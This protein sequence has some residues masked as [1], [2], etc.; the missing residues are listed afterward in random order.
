[1][2]FK[3]IRLDKSTFHSIFL[4]HFS[5]QPTDDQEILVKSLIDFIFTKES[6][7]LFLLKGYAGTGKTTILGAF[8]KSLLEAKA[9][10]KLLAPTGRAAKVLAGKSN[11]MANTIHKFIYRRA[12]SSDGAFR[13]SLMPN[14]HKH[15]LFIVDEASMIGDYTLQNDGQVSS[16]NLLEDLME[17]VYSGEGCKLILLGD[18]GQLPPVGADFS[19]ALNA[20]YIQQHFPRCTITEVKLSQ[21]VRQGEGSS[22]LLNATALRSAEEGEFPSF[23]LENKGDLI[24]LPGDEIQERIENSYNQVGLE[25]TILITRSN[26]RANQYNQLIRS[27]IFDFEEELC[28]GDLLMAV[29]NN[30]FWLADDSS[31]GFIANGEMLVVKRVIR[32]EELYGFRFAEVTVQFVDYPQ[33]VERDILVLLDTLDVEGPNL[34]RD[35]MKKLFFAVEQDYLDEHNKKKRYDKI[36]KNPH[37][38]ALQVK[39][40]YAVTCHKSQG[41]QW[42]NVFLD[43]GYLTEE[44]LDAGYFRWL[45][46]ALTRATE[47]V[48]LMNFKDEFF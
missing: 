48:Y 47:K 24:R 38:N 6:H 9:R 13:V 25:E 29:K 36:L 35:E 32:R 23:K 18:E 16:S 39:Y 8:V 19:P 22:V 46:T 40:A 4:E 30:Y 31:I 21:V 33:E 41:G 14:L 5:Q 11:Q 17:F 12:V 34:P 1:L 42:A 2:I 43:Q 15:T 26:K 10:V 20:Q 7:Q 45:Y 28:S 3:L 37:F 44:M 27:S